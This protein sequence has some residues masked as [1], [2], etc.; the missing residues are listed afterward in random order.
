MGCWD[1][2][3]AL[4]RTAIRDSEPC[5]MTRFSKKK[6]KTEAFGEIESPFIFRCV[7]GIYKGTYNAYGGLNKNPELNNNSDKEYIVFVHQSVWDRCQFLTD[8]QEKLWIERK[9]ETRRTRQRLQESINSLGLIDTFGDDE[10][11]YL[12]IPF[13][14]E[15]STVMLMCALARMDFLSTPRTSRQEWVDEYNTQLMVQRLR[16]EILDY[17]AETYKEI[18]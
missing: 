16:S 5:V 17:Q 8:G 7:T 9:K 6:F 13:I 10:N 11:D 3:C 2:T 4:T 14:D 15:L 12:D 18:E 1:E